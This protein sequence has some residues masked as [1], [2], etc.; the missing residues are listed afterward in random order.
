MQY[1]LWFDLFPFV[2][3]NA[4]SVLSHFLP[5]LQLEESTQ[6]PFLLG[7]STGRRVV[8]NEKHFMLYIP[9]STA[10]MSRT[11]HQASCFKC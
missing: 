8:P 4:N 3:S 9:G 7:V 5:S 11:R 6:C 10:W 2:I 1:K